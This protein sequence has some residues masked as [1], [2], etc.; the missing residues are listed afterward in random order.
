MKFKYGSLKSWFYHHLA[1]A[2]KESPV[3][4]LYATQSFDDQQPHPYDYTTH[5]K[6]YSVNVYA[7]AAMRAIARDVSSTPF[8]VQQQIRQDGDL[9]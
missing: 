9:I 7:Y 8:M 2:F 4:R 3:G 5:L 6:V 1:E